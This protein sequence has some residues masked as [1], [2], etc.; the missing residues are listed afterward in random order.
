LRITLPADWQVNQRS[1][2][3]LEAE[4][5]A[6][7]STLMVAK[8]PAAVAG[9]SPSLEAVDEPLFRATELKVKDLEDR[10]TRRV[11]AHGLDCL[12]HEMIGTFRDR[13][14]FA[15]VLTTHAGHSFYRAS[16]L[17]EDRLEKERRDELEAILKSIQPQ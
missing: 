10:G 1:E 5:D 2:Y 8:F 3:E 14:C 11:T 7:A 12:V 17:T 4:G 13:R 6:K 9:E 15:M 16:L